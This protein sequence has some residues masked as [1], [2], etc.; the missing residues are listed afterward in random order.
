MNVFDADHVIGQ[1][2]L[3]AAGRQAGRPGDEDLRRQVRQQAQAVSDLIR[4][5]RAPAAGPK[6][7]GIVRTLAAPVLAPQPALPV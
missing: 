4:R 2:D 7:V 3:A 5:L 6:A 1:V